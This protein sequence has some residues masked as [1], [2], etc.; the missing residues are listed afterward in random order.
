MIYGLVESSGLNQKSE[1]GF[2]GVQ[3]VFALFEYK[4]V[5]AVYD[6]GRYFKPAARGERVHKLRVVR[7]ERHKLVVDLIGR[8]NFKLFFDER[9]VL[10]VAVGIN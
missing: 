4:S 10:I 6:F 5:F 7:R 3:F 2:Y 8:E 1:N 9:S